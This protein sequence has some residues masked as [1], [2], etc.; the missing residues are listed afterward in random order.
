MLPLV[1]N[2]QPAAAPTAPNAVSAHAQ[3]LPFSIVS[4][5]ASAARQ[6]LPMAVSALGA[7]VAYHPDTLQSRQAASERRVAEQNDEQQT[8]DQAGDEVAQNA[9][10][11]AKLPAWAQRWLNVPL[12]QRAPFSSLFAAQFMAQDVADDALAYFSPEPSQPAPL[13]LPPKTETALPSQT[14]NAI[15]QYY[16]HN[17]TARAEKPFTKSPQ[18][19]AELRYAP[20]PRKPGLDRATGAMAYALAVNR[21]SATAGTVEAA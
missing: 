16:A 4:D 15:A 11:L 2:V 1:A 9:A 10:R 17:G 5:E 21:G 12:M 3:S 14:R 13:A 8:T 7:P 18:A 6:Q 19:L 20:I